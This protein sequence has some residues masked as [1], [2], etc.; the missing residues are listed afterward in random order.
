M[1][2]FKVQNIVP[3]GGKYFYFVEQT[4]THFEAYTLEDVLRKVHDNLTA[5]GHPVPENLKALVCDY[6]CRH[7]P[8]KFC[9]GDAEN[10]PRIRALTMFQ[11]MEFTSLLFKRF[12][13]SR[14]KFFVAQ[15]E[16][17]RR[18]GICAKCPENNR[19][20]CTTCN[21]L[22]PW[23]AKMVA[24]RKTN[25]DKILG[26]CTICGCVLSAKIHVALEYLKGSGKTV[27]PLN[28]WLADVDNTREPEADK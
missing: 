5:N 8:E 20:I 17:V 1:L 22:K 21:G 13:V 15:P 25:L 3:P 12:T 18:A 9:I 26:V 27:Y 16:A 24:N 2:R 4:S 14:D 6:I 11:I 23:A 7:V 19:T 10:R 28:C